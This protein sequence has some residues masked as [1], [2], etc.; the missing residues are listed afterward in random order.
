M[1]SA[2]SAKRRIL[3]GGG[4]VLVCAIIVSLLFFHFFYRA[5][6]CSDGVQNGDETGVDCGGS[7]ATLC[8][9]QTIAPI[10]YWAKAFNV[11]GDVYN[12][13]AYVENSNIDSKNPQASYDFKVYDANNILIAERTGTTFIP[14]NQK[15]IIFEPDLTIQN[16]IPKRVDFE[17]TDFAPWQKD[18]TTDPSISVTYSP[19]QSTTTSPRITGTVTNNS[20]QN[21][22]NGLELS[23][24]VLDSNQNAVAV[25]RTFTDPMPQ[26]TSQDFVFTWP[27]PFSLGVQ[28]CQSPVDVALSLDRSGSMKSEQ[29]NPPEPF[30]TVKQTAE[31]FINT[32]QTGDN[33]AVVSFGSAATVESLLSG[34]LSKAVSSIDALSLGTTSEQTDIGDGLLS[35][36]TQLDSATDNNKKIIILL[37]D[38]VPNEPTVTGNSSYPSVYAQSAAESLEASGTALYT[39][40]LGKSVDTNFLQ[41]LVPNDSYYFFAP[42]KSDLSAIYNTIS[43]SLCV[44]KP[45]VVI[46][47]YRI[48]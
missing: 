4:F 15:F 16:K 18:V 20:D 13:A 2:W 34:D 12:I 48:L 46:V 43:S 36:E 40:G 39:I 28:S 24:L 3:Y 6:S 35:A 37:T 31:D 26:K 41:S 5:P 11:L 21:L 8:S 10:V 1:I 25:S 9:N 38:G 23:V 33:V 22:D 42:T 17:F 14:K 27:K 45:S 7:C 47:L 44:K 32:L 29:A 30:S 19:L